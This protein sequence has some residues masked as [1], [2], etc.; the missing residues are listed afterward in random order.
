[1]KITT[2]TPHLGT[3]EE[4]GRRLILVRKQQ[5]YTQAQLAKEAGLGV[6]T[7]IRIERG[8]DAQFSS[9]IKILNILDKSPAIDALLPEQIRSPMSEVQRQRRQRKSATRSEHVWGDG[10]S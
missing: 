3:L 1:M 5:G 10:K 6:V 4:L 8:Q 9:W 2:T 7:V